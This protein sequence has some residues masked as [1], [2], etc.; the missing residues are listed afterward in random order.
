MSET[1]FY[2]L[3]EVKEHQTKKV[4][5]IFYYSSFLLELFPALGVLAYMCLFSVY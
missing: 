3:D 2:T 1:K 5:L 4:Y